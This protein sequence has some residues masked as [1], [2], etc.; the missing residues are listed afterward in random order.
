MDPSWDVIDASPRWALGLVHALVGHLLAEANGLVWRVDPDD[1]REDFGWDKVV[2]IGDGKMVILILPGRFKSWKPLIFFVYHEKSIK[3]NPSFLIHDAFFR[4]LSCEAFFFKA[5]TNGCLLII[6]H[7]L[8]NNGPI[9]LLHRNQFSLK[10]PCLIDASMSITEKEWSSMLFGMIMAFM[11]L[12]TCLING[13]M[14]RWNHFIEWNELKT[15]L[16]HCTLSNL[17]TSKS[18]FGSRGCWDVSMAVV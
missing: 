15:W 7:G 12:A 17:N 9:D 14:I 11:A 2:Q 6:H 3:N 4:G 1:Y 10:G 18:K 8:V 16:L 13:M 5:D